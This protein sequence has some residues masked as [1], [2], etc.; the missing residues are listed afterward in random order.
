M[1]NDDATADAAP[2]LT[3]VVL[4]RHGESVGNATQAIHGPRMCGGLSDAGREQCERLAERLARTGELAGA[5]LYASQFRRAQETAKLIAPS[6]GDPEIVVDDGFGEIDWGVE[7][8]GLAFTEIVERFGTPDWD[9]DPEVPFVAGGESSADMTRRVTAAVD[10]VIARH[11]GRVAVVCTHGGAIDVAVRYAFGVVGRGQFDL[12]T[13]NT[14]LTTLTY[15]SV[16][17]N[18]RRWRI[19]RYN[20]ASH[21]I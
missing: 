14:S 9:G 11:P 10:R 1:A 18:W 6:L 19:E 2:V 3:S 7:C 4:I 13:T 21:L 16:G 15:V 17:T 8:D 5:V 20:D 12:Y